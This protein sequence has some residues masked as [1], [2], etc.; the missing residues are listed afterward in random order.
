MPVNRLAVGRRV[1]G[2]ADEHPHHGLRL[3]VGL[4]VREGAGH[5]GDISGVPPRI[6]TVPADLERRPQLSLR[7]GNRAW[8]ITVDDV[9]EL[10]YAGKLVAHERAGAFPDVA[11]DAGHACVRRR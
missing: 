1:T 9:H 7:G 6:V 3:G 2:T 5:V 11:L 4:V 10:T 8:E